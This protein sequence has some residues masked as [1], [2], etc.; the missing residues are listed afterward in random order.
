[1]WAESSKT[2]EQSVHE[3]KTA[4]RWRVG[5]SGRRPHRWT[6]PGAQ[7]GVCPA[8]SSDVAL[9]LCSPH[10]RPPSKS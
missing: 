10:P 8:C 4:G 2:E 5:G 3:A 6:G 1:M 7:L 9:P